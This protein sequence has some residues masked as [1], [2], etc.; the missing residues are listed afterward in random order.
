MGKVTGFLE[1]GRENTPHRPVAE[2]I[3]RLARG[4][5]RS[6]ARGG[7][8]A[9]G[10]L[11]GLRHPV[12][13][14]R[15]PARQHHPGLE[16]LRLPRQ[17]AGRAGAPALDEQLPG[18][19]RARVSRAVR[20]GVRARHQPGSRSRSSRSSGRSSGAAGTRASSR[21]CDPRRAAVARWRWWARVRR[22]SRRRSS[23]A[24][25]VTA[26]R[27][28]RRATA[29]A[30]CCATAFPTSSSRSGSS[31]AA[32]TRCARK[33]SSSRPACTSASISRPRELR[34]HFDAV[35]LCMGSEQPRDLPVPGRE[36][37]GVH[38]A[39]EFLAQ[40]NKRVAGDA[41]PD[42]E[43]ILA[44]GKHV[45]VLGGGDTGSDCVGTSHRQ[46]AKS[47][48]SIE[49][50]ERPPD[51]RDASTPWPQLA[52][53][54]PLVEFARRGRDARLRGDDEAAARTRTAASRSCT[55]CACAICRPIP[56]RAGATSRRSRAATSR[57]PRTWC[58]WRW[59]SS[60]PSRRG[61]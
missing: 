43:A 48:T 21:R 54:V 39:M 2:R 61:S 56:G 17:V 4:A 51:Q 58:C 18:V 11:H 60:I 41:I 34:K 26:S 47:V 25:R 37:A 10:A 29:S 28:S 42:E 5:A 24:A 1:F 52:A 27:S 12:L 15:L 44:T 45:I 32:S 9:G 6:V 55:A 59:A 22:V 8:E 33:A 35:L 14:Q 20:S 7:E 50:L 57:F 49:L 16:R 19:H 53:D 3:A 40:N 36:L 13:Q 38:F 23:S 31:T 30:V 46:G